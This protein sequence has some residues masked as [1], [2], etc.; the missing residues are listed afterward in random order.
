MA[1]TSGTGL[2]LRD[3]TILTLAYKGATAEQI[4]AE[5]QVSPER[6]AIELN[7]L[8]GSIDWLSDLQQYRLTFHGLQSLVGNLRELAESGQD[9][10]ITKAYLE[11]IRLVFEQLEAQRARVDADIERVEAAQARKLLEIV[12]RSFYHALGKLEATF[13]DAGVPR[14]AIEQAFQDSIVMI[15][16]E[17]DEREQ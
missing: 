7:R 17:Y 3:S 9:A 1:K 8:T 12:D 13:R 16:A 2:S 4:G 10:H 11:A 15:A 6:V 5:L 14:E